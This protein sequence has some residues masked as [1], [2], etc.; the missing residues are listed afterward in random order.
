MQRPGSDRA[1]VFLAQALSG[2][3]CM[4]V[5]RLLLTAEAAVAGR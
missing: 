3:A 1:L 4:P 5:L 2:V